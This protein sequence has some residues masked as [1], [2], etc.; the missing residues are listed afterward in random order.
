MN[1]A[2]WITGAAGFTGR[3]LI[4]FLH[5]LPDRPTLIGLDVQSTTVPGLDALHTLDLGDSSAVRTLACQR[6][7]AVVI[8]LAGLLPPAGDADMWRV[9]VGGT[10]ALLH[11][12]H[13][14]GVR[15]TRIVGVGSAAEYSRDASS[16]LREDAPCAGASPY[17]ITKVAQTQ[18]CRHLGD[19][20]GFSVAVAR[21]FNL[22]GPGLPARFVAGALVRQ[23]TDSADGVVRVGNTHTARDFIDVRDAVR[24][25]WMLA[26]EEGASGVFNVC[27]G[28]PTSVADLLQLLGTVTGRAGRAE[29]DPARVRA[30][31][32]VAVYGDPGRL[33]EA[34]GWR[35]LIPLEQSL[36]DML[37]RA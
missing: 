32:P 34:T 11:G 17:G 29:I 36:R 37:P 16:P 8:H 5:A 9:N 10:A 22:I 33:R 15:T 20:F 2:V 21:P 6:P 12:L 35:P 26:A 27:S 25:Y 1:E 24:A 28:T 7:P 14:A 19:A 18:M 23:F 3:H 31:D 30:D 4:A 13:D